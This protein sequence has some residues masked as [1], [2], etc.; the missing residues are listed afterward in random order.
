MGYVKVQRLA[1]LVSSTRLYFGVYDLF[2]P[3]HLLIPGTELYTRLGLSSPNKIQET[4]KYLDFTNLAPKYKTK[5]WIE[6][7]MRPEE[8]EDLK[9]FSKIRKKRPKGSPIYEALCNKRI[10]DFR[11]MFKNEYEAATR[12][13]FPFRYTSYSKNLDRY[14]RNVI[15]PG[16]IRYLESDSRGES[17]PFVAIRSYISLYMSKKFGW[18]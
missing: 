8:R 12:G 1:R 2:C 9:K 5:F 10:V 4:K 11:L 14:F 18:I 15:I 3:D 6:V 7:I 16:Y 13:V 17:V